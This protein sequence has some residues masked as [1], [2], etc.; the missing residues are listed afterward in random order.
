MSTR[1][2]LKSWIFFIDQKGFARLQVTL[3][4]ENQIDGDGSSREYGG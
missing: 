1:I 4:P 3:S 2:S